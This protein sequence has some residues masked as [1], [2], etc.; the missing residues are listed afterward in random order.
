VLVLYL[1]CSWIVG[2]VLAVTFQLAHCVDVACFV[3]D[4]AQRRGDQ[5]VAH[6]LL[7][8]VDITS[9]VPLAGHAFRWLAG[10]LDCQIEHHLAPRLPHT[11]YPLVAARFRRKCS[12]VGISCRVH[13]SVWAALCSH[14]RWLK[15]M[16]KPV[17][18]SLVFGRI[19]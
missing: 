3:D 1:G 15:A 4:D 8:T 11:I 13:T 16:G 9:K 17:V 7:T 18:P 19:S 6:Q 2:F 10:G 12:E 5:F 14:G